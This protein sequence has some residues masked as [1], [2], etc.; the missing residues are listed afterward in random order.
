MA[1]YKGKTV[2]VDLAPSVIADKFSDLTQFGDKINTLDPEQ[3]S[4]LGDIRFEKDAILVKNPAVGEL[5]FR[6]V[7]HSPSRIVFDAGGMI[8]MSLIV[9]LGAVSES[10]NKTDVTTTIDIELPLM[11]RGILGGKLQQVADSF[12]DFVGKLSATN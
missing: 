7:E 1:K 5:V 9:D 12:G 6:R 8:P 2:R 4:K 10:E 11:L 3:R